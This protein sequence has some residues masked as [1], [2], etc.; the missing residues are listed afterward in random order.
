MHPYVFQTNLFSL[1]WENVMIAVAILAGVWLAQRRAAH[2]GPAYQNMLLDLAIWLILS[3]V[4]GARLWEM[5]FTWPEYAARPWEMLA[6]WEGGLSIQGAILGGL[7]AT[8]IFARRRRLRVWELLDILAPPVILG[9]AIGR[10]GCFLSGDAFGRPISEVPW[11]PGWIGVVYAPQSPAYYLFGATPL[12]PAELM[13]MFLGFAILAFLLLY[14]PLREV[15]GRT[16]LTYA[17][18]YSMARFNLEFVRADSLTVGGIKTAQALSLIVI[19][20]CLPWL[21]VRSRDAARQTGAQQS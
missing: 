15:A 7:L 2:K 3:G 8:L 14:R 1:R 20:I 16:V 4:A 9:Q 17:V 13:E 5:L 19:L 11:L 6:V 18:L 21:H 10:I 12:I